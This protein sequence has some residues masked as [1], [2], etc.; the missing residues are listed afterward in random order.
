MVRLG[1]GFKKV[2]DLVEKG[3]FRDSVGLALIGGGRWLGWVFF[4]F[5][6]LDL[7]F[8]VLMKGF[9]W[10]VWGSGDLRDRGR[11]DGG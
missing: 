10:T 1:L 2:W 7:G 5:F 4:F 9:P 11:S 3:W 8:G 6:L